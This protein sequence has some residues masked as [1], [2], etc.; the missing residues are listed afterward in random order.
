KPGFGL[1]GAVPR[2]DRVSP[3]VRVC[4]PST[5]TQSLLFLRSRLR[6]GENCSTASPLDVHTVRLLLD[7]CECSEASRQT[8]DCSEYSS[9]SIAFAKSAH[10]RESIDELLLPASVTAGRPR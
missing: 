8:A 3:L 10:Y 5:P 4:M 2:L 6:S 9:R 7:S 1:S